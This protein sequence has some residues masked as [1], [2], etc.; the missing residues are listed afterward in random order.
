MR[1]CEERTSVCSRLPSRCRSGSAS[2]WRNNQAY[3][4]ALLP[5]S[6]RLPTV[7]CSES[8]TYSA[9]FAREAAPPRRHHTR[10]RPGRRRR[11]QCRSVAHQLGARCL[12]RRHAAAKCSKSTFWSA[13]PMALQ[14]MPIMPGVRS[15]RK[16][17]HCQPCRRMCACCADLSAG[18]LCRLLGP[19]RAKSGLG[20]WAQQTSECGANDSV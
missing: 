11:A 13:A 6:A 5:S 2:W 17:Q 9:A 20:R 19:S 10:K 4:L 15:L 1:G 16:V 12:G 7:S 8:Q 18:F 14:E 3:M